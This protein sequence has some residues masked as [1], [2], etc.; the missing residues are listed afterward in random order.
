MH[1]SGNI[2][3]TSEF[4]TLNKWTVW[5]VN[6]INKVFFN[7]IFFSIKAIFLPNLNVD[8]TYSEVTLPIISKGIQPFIMIMIDQ[9]AIFP[10]HCFAFCYSFPWINIFLLSPFK[11]LSIL[12]DVAQTPLPFRRCQ[13]FP[14]M[15]HIS[16]SSA[17]SCHMV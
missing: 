11:I 12:H 2:L 16:F 7:E 15:E 5:Y 3:K 9:L 1:I 17:W 4:Y 10:L 6:Y 13:Q 14:T 8:S